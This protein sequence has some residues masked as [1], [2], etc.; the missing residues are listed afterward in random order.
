MPAES[1][2]LSSIQAL[3]TLIREHWV[4]AGEGEVRVMPLLAV[5]AILPMEQLATLEALGARLIQ[6]ERD[7][8]SG[9]N[10]F[11]GLR[12]LPTQ[13]H[14]LM[15]VA[16]GYEEVRKFATSPWVSALGALTVD[17]HVLSG[18]VRYTAQAVLERDASVQELHAKVKARTGALRAAVTLNYDEGVELRCLTELGGPG[19]RCLSVPWLEE[20]APLSQMGA[21]L[22]NALD[23]LLA[24]AVEMLAP[25]EQQVALEE[26]AC[27]AFQAWFA[28]QPTEIRDALRAQPWLLSQAVAQSEP[29]SPAI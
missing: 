5:D 17:R 24:S 25:L 11:A 8:G 28:T 16:I 7:Y 10:T 19:G 22:D 12:T 15:L 21:W 2:F 14:E 27:Q 23:S 6:F 26:R 29:P 9:P 18:L 3:C 13:L 4:P 20:D 1:P